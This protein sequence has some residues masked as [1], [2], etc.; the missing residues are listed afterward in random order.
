[1][2]KKIMPLCL[3]FLLFACV[4]KEP[5]QNTVDN[6]L[7]MKVMAGK[8]F[9]LE[10]MN[11]RSFSPEDYKKPTLNFSDDLRIFGQICN[12]FNGAATI[13]DGILKAEHMISTRMFCTNPQLNEL[14]MTFFT[15]MGKGAEI[16]LQGDAISLRHG[17]TLLIYKQVD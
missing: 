3:V 1:M 11:G 10:T 13:E 14:E 2:L 9:V 16:V 15:M 6:L 8:S 17:D 7:S 12:V 4:E 5:A